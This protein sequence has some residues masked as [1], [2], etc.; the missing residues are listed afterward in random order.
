VDCCLFVVPLCVLRTGVGTK[1][2]MEGNENFC[3]I[4][5]CY[6]KQSNFFPYEADILSPGDAAGAKVIMASGIKFAAT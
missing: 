2:A 4:M 6:S 5:A 1:V 3:S